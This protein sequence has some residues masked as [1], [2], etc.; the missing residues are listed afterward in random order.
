MTAMTAE[1]CSTP[2]AGPRRTT[3][4]PSSGYPMWKTAQQARRSRPDRSPR[5]RPGTPSK[6]PVA[7]GAP[8]P[9]VAALSRSRDDGAVESRLEG[10]TP[11]HTNASTSSAASSPAPAAAAGRRTTIVLA[12][13]A[14]AT[15]PGASTCLGGGVGRTSCVTRSRNSASA[16]IASSPAVQRALQ[17]SRRPWQVRQRP[18]WRTGPA[19][20]R[21]AAPRRERG[22]PPADRR[23]GAGQRP[24]AAAVPRT[25][26]P[27]SVQSLTGFRAGFGGGERGDLEGAQD[28]LLVLAPQ[29]PNLG[30]RRAQFQG[31]APAVQTARYEQLVHLLPGLGQRGHDLLEP[32]AQRRQPAAVPVVCGDGRHLIHDLRICRSRGST[33]DR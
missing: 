33:S 29:A 20:G 22:R 1:P 9:M 26:N 6:V 16:R 4:Q 14:G 19:G 32:L 3:A 15:R 25:Q 21:R 18:R 5:S 30:R 8:V 28:G 7:V 31:R 12:I 13:P 17:S 10:R 24:V 11:G 23:R 2:M 27:R